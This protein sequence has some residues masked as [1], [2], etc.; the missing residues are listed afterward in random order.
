MHVTV[1]VIYDDDA[2]NDAYL[3]S[4]ESC[5]HTIPCCVDDARV[6]ALLRIKCTADW[7]DTGIIDNTVA[8]V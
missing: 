7:L 2:A 1:M 4:S 6:S 8:T 3:G 5:T